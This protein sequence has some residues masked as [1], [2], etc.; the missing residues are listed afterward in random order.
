MAAT[1]RLP[2]F[3][4]DCQTGITHLLQFADAWDAL[5]QEYN[6]M[7]ANGVV[8]TDADVAELGVTAAQFN[9]A[10]GAMQEVVDHAHVATRAAKLYRV[11]R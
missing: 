3:V 10:L 7:Q 6:A 8:I 1:L 9:A 5:R 2:G 11:K 4:T